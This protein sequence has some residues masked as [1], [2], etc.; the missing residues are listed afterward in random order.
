LTGAERTALLGDGRSNGLIRMC[1]FH[2][3]YGYEDFIE[4]IKPRIE[5]NTVLFELKDGIFKQICQDAEKRPERDF[6]LIIDEIN[7]GEISRIFG[8]LITLIEHNKRGKKI[9]LPISG[10][11]FQ[12]PGNV[13]LIGTMNTADRSIA[14][15]DIA[16]RRR[17][18]FKEFLPE[19]ELLEGACIGSLPMGKWLRCLNE[20]ISQHL[21]REARNLQIG[22][23]YFMKDE[24]AIASED[25]FKKILAEDIL[26]LLEE[27]CYGDYEK[28]TAILG[29]GLVDPKAQTLQY[30]LFA[31][32][33]TEL[34]NA[35]LELCPEIRKAEPQG[36]IA[37]AEDEVADMED[38][39]TEGDQA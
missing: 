5:N 14:L 20:R 3:S 34:E 32:D 16:L 17:F 36:K 28:L 22:H 24:K 25:F 11:N 37:A 9:A 6:Y 13:Y 35:L 18:G 12:V 29:S 26:P 27:Y 38:E 15:L 7:R 23:S 4:G 39:T 31:K 10:R 21:G 30:K 1:C 19:Y 33:F 8:E 2:P